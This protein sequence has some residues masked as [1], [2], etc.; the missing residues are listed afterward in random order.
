MLLC[1]G[2]S[3]SYATHVKSLSRHKVFLSCCPLNSA[4]LA[5]V[6]RHMHSCVLLRYVAAILPTKNSTGFFSLLVCDILMISRRQNV[7]VSG[8]FAK[9][10]A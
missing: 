9:A 4:K 3:L 5:D 1:R 6:G 7:V 10:G 8:R 2:K